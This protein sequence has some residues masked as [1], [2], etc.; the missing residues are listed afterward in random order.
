MN[1]SAT[2]S[3]SASASV[4]A[5]QAAAANAKAA[6]GEY[7]A[8]NMQTSQTKDSDGDYKPNVAASYPAATSSPGVQAALTTL[9]KGG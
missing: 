1:V 4:A 7:L 3:P 5:P 8:P 9:A 2:G 6:D